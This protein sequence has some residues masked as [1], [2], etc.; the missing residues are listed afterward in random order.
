MVGAGLCVAIIVG[1]HCVAHGIVVDEYLVFG[2]GC[3]A[4][5][6]MQRAMREDDYVLGDDGGQTDKQQWCL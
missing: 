1:D 5:V 4:S 6:L 2:G 3:K